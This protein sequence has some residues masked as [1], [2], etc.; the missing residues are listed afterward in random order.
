MEPVSE[1]SAGDRERVAETLDRIVL[2]AFGTYFE[3]LR[4]YRPFARETIGLGALLG[5]EDMYAAEI[6]GWTTLPLGPDELHRLGREL[7]EHL[8]EEGRKIAEELGHPDLRAAVAAHAATGRDT[9]SSREEVLN[10]AKR[11]VQRSWKAAPGFFGKMP[12][13]NCRVRAVDPSVE[14]HILDYYLGPSEDG[15]RPGVFYVNCAPRPL[16]SM[17][18]TTYH[19]SNP[20]HHFQAMIDLETPDRAAIRRFGNELQ[21]VAFSEGWGLYSERVADEMGLYVDSYERLGM[22]E[23]QAL[24]AARLVVDTGIH[25]FGWS[26]EQA[27]SLLEETGQPDWKASAEVDRY[28]AM[29]GQALC[30]TVGQLDI[31]R[32][33][34]KTG[35]DEDRRSLRLFHDRLLSLGA[36][37]LPAIR[38][39]MRACR[40]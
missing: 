18:T 23:L 9:P 27:I 24:R 29:P 3:S 13:A 40:P 33:R 35:A 11:Q 20:G 1:G 34:S 25:A 21:G 2:P 8:A 12:S 4:R 17:A 32:L 10:R 5:G 22:L 30:Y 15:S 19:E 36:L 16:H 31:E 37:P 28:I 14:E 26:R 6:L 38:R 7:L 39:E